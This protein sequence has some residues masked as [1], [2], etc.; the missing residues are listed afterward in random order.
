MYAILC[1]SMKTY[2]MYMYVRIYIYIYRYIC[3]CMHLFL[4][5][6]LCIEREAES[7]SYTAGKP[8]WWY[9]LRVDLELKPRM[10]APST[11]TET[12]QLG[13]LQGSPRIYWRAP[14][15]L[16]T[17]LPTVGAAVIANFLAPHSEDSY[18]TGFRYIKSSSNSFGMFFPVGSYHIPFCGYSGA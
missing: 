17:H 9:L 12:L 8:P 3:I 4:H 2:C 18:S 6:H 11:H 13:P 16:H 7:D 5:I 10:G 14:I 1:T 15:Q